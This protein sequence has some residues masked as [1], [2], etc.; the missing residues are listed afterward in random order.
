M[1]RNPS[2]ASMSL[3]GGASRM[4]NKAVKVVCGEWAERDRDP[5][6]E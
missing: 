4:M 6:D 5:T 1:M 3:G 2:V